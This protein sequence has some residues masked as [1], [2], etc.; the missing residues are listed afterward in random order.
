[1]PNGKP[2]GVRCI[3]LDKNNLCELFGRPERPELCL[4]FKADVWV[5]GE[6]REDALQLLSNLE[7]ITG[8]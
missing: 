4:Q 2:A 8:V 6:S 3:N 1:M 7:Q 5:C